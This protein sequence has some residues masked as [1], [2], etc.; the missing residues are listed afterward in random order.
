MGQRI[1]DYAMIGD[2]LAAGLVGVDGS[3][4]WLCLPRFD[5]DACFAALLGDDEHGRW[6][7]APAGAGRCT[8]RRYRGDTLVLETEWET[9]DGAVR[10][11][12]FMPERNETPDVVRIVEGRSGRVAMESR[13]RLRFGY[14]QIAPWFQETR[15][16][17]VGIVGPDAVTLRGP[18]GHAVEGGGSHDDLV[19]RFEVGEGERVPFVLTWSESFRPPP[20]RT[21]AEV[22]LTETERFWQ[23]WADRCTYQ[24]P[25]REAVVRSAVTLKA[26]TYAPTGGI[27][28]AATTSLPE[29][30][31]G[32]RNWD[33][34][35]C[36]LRDSTFT[37]Q[38][39]LWT[40]Y[41]REAKEWREWLLRAVAGQPKHLQIMYAAAGERRLQEVELDWLPGYEGS[42]PVR[43][44]NAAVDQFQLDVYGEVIDTLHLAREHGLEAESHAWEMQRALVDYVDSRWREPDAGLW[45]VRGDQRHHVHSKVLAWVGVDRAVQAVETRELDGPVDKWRAL[46]EEIAREICDKGYDADRQTFTMSYGM[47]ALDA[48]TLLIPQVG[49]LPP[50]DPRVRGTVAAI[51]RELMHHG[52][53]RRYDIGT[54]GGDDGLPGR[55]AT[56]LACTLWLA[57]DYCLMGRDDDARRLME[58]VLA[59]RNDVG[60]LSEEYDPERG[61]LMG[62]VPQAFS[63]VPVI[64][65]ARLLSSTRRE[66]PRSGRGAPLEEES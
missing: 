30:L 42:R 40:G 10:V 66:H 21:D 58:R 52:F 32:V 57:D 59:V 14:G 11:I 60:L 19:A 35:Y 23:G 51:E 18:L 55:E 3:M 5:S 46:R 12:D 28:A 7:L 1:E 2:R 50:E 45:E 63:H 38:A 48:A 64:N 62:N 36:W 20:A 39:L 29:T 31:G 15:E 4:D 41:E 37:L 54:R 33:Y 17:L 34:R 16:G 49:L 9:R 25:W 61:R 22:A 56:F 6:L 13:L 53:L 27:V 44:G 26:L 65:T 24:G 43:V 47:E 8:R